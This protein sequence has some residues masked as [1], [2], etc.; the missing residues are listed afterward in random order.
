MLETKVKI[1][2]DDPSRFEARESY[3]PW[4]FG[5]PVSF[6]DHLIIP[7]TWIYLLLTGSRRI[8]IDT[9]NREIVIQHGHFGLGIARHIRFSEIRSIFRNK[10]RRHQT[11]LDEKSLNRVPRFIVQ[12]V[13][14][15]GTRFIEV[16]SYNEAS[17]DSGPPDSYLKSTPVNIDSIYIDT[18]ATGYVRLFSSIPDDAAV[19]KATDFISRV[20]GFA[21]NEK[22]DKPN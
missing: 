4:P 20:A 7:F 10:S 13:P 18:A 22:N 16:P 5:G 6:F 21:I 2:H 17:R 15:S 19:K 8:T 1:I 3:Y 11:D 9:S 12:P 14:I